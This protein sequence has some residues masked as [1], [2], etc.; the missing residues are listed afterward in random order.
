MPIHPADAGVIK[1]GATAVEFQEFVVLILTGAAAA[2][3][4]NLSSQSGLARDGGMRIAPG[5]DD[6]S[7]LTMAV[8]DR[9][10]STD[11]VMEVD[12]TRLFLEPTIT[13]TLRGKVL[14][15]RIGEHGHV[16]FVINAPSR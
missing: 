9:P 14:D 7:L 10:A 5:Q 12:G 6:P 2:A 1:I 3:I 13:A 4:R 8:T 15:A 16:V 11:E